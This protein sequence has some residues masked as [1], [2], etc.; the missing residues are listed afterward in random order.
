MAFTA[1]SGRRVATPTLRKWYRQV[2][3]GERS[4]VEIERTELGEFNARGKALTRLF[5]SE[6][7]IDSNLV[8][9]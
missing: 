1:K 5:A 2:Q 7:G 4:K 6:L 9:R 8:L 3:N